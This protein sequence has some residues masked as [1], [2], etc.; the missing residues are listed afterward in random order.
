MLLAAQEL[1]G[2]F[3]ALS[4]LLA[5]LPSSSSSSR[6]NDR[7]FFVHWNRANILYALYQTHNGDSQAI[8]EIQ[9]ALKL[10]P[11]DAE[12]QHLVSQSTR[13]IRPTRR[14][15]GGTAGSL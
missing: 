5:L 6:H 10:R 15:T 8:R 7:S 12:A 9:A 11:H 13:R 4:G 2:A 14:C 1:S 3:D